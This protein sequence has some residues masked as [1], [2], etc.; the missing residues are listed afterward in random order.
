METKEMT[1][2]IQLIV[3][4][5]NKSNKLWGRIEYNG[6]LLIDSADTI[7]ELTSK[8]Q[9]VIQTMYNLHPAG[10]Q[11]ELLYDL[12]ALFKEKNYLNLSALADRAGINRSL[13]A[14]Y[15]AGIKLPSLERASIIEQTIHG[16]GNELRSVRLAVKSKAVHSYAATQVIAG[17][18]DIIESGEGI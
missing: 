9:T 11:L 5:E 6:S 1:T 4:K 15:A 14:Q 10:Y 13:M 2:T 8:M 18:D 12:T 17:D 16:F 3:E 7:E